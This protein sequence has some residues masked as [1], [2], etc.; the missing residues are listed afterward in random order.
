MKTVKIGTVTLPR[1]G[2]I[3]MPAVGLGTWGMGERPDRAEAE[4]AALRHAHDLGFRHFD[5]AEMYADGGAEEVMGRAFAGLARDQL[6]LVS[7]FYPQNASPEKMAEACERSLRRLGTD[8]LDLY[9]LHWPGSVDIART[10]EGAEALTDAGRI[11]AFG[12]SN[13]DTRGVG[14]IADRGL[15][16]PIT[17]NQVMHNIPERGIEVDLLP[18]M[19]REEIVAVAYSPLETGPMAGIDGMEGIA[20]DLGLT[21]AQLALAWHVTRG[22]TVPIP[23]SANTAHLDDLA[24]AVETTLD[25]ETLARIDRLAPAPDRPVPLAIR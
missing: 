14:R 6:F 7:K 17:V 12:I 2:G 8:Y 18:L 10:V 19:A 25:A 21:L 11:R 4:I 9:L 3:E 22:L 16:G 5:T 13:F 15:L 23:K 1:T 20:G 24:R